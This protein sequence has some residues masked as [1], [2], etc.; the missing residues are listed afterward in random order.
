MPRPLAR[1]LACVLL[2]SAC[3][4]KEPTDTAPTD[5]TDTGT[6][7]LS[8][9]ETPIDG[10][11]AAGCQ[12]QEAW[13]YDAAGAC[14]VDALEPAFCRPSPDILC[15]WQ[16]D[17]V[18]LTSPEGVTWYVDWS[19]FTVPDGWTVEYVPE[20]R[21]ACSSVLEC[22]DLSVDACGTAVGCQVMDAWPYNEPDACY[23]EPQQPAF[24]RPDPDIVCGWEGDP[25]LME[26]REGRWWY[27]DWSCFTLPRDW[28][29]TFVPEGR[30]PC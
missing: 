20:G 21:E 26:D 7:P 28:A 4:S 9:S 16:G 8:C 29:C 1:L 3:P 6:A 22:G 13:P 19:C 18:L 2:T 12:V 30:P 15:D 27:Q 11:L 14:Y 24:C 23:E 17:P 25:V 5:T 10:C